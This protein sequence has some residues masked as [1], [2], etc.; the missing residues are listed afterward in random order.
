MNKERTKTETERVGAEEEIRPRNEV[1][2]FLERKL[3]THC[4]KLD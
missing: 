2:L 3:F 1:N 4:L